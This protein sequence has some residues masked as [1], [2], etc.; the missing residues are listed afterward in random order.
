MYSK[1]YFET[2]KSL[3]DKY[4]LNITEIALY[5]YYDDKWN[6]LNTTN[7]E[8][9]SKSYNFTAHTPGFSYFA[10]AGSSLPTVVSNS[11]INSSWIMTNQTISSQTQGD[12]L[13]SLSKT[14]IVIGVAGLLGILAYILFFRRKQPF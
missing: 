7:T 10:I 3:V 1:I 13:D 12:L 9:S 4:N 8:Q 11:S 6:Q 5:R 14:L 2:P